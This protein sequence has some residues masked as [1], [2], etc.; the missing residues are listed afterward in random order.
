MLNKRKLF[1]QYFKFYVSN[2]NIQKS[3]VT[4]SQS[5]HFTIKCLKLQQANQYQFTIKCLIH[6]FSN[7]FEII[8]WLLLVLHRTC[9]QLFQKN[10]SFCTLSFKFVRVCG[11]WIF[12]RNRVPLH[13]PLSNQNPSWYAHSISYCYSFHHE[14]S[15]IQLA[16]NDCIF[17]WYP[18][19]LGSYLRVESNF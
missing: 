8:I 2:S 18:V 10:S 1:Y 9:N 19:D 12:Y 16:L 15:S 14:V 13:V 11:Q 17:S 6:T 4:S 5:Y 3:E 7:L